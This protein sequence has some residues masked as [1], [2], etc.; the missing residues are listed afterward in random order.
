MYLAEYLFLL[1]KEKLNSSETIL[2]KE[3]IKP[4]K[5]QHSVSLALTIAN[6]GEYKGNLQGQEKWLSS[7]VPLIWRFGPATG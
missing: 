3:K 2:T 1:W 6:C 7:F 5:G 4:Q